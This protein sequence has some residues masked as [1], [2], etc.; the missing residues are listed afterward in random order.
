[1]RN[2]ATV[3]GALLLSSLLVVCAFGMTRTHD[4]A[5][6]PE[7]KVAPT[8]TPVNDPVPLFP[9]C[10]VLQI[11][12]G[13]SDNDGY[14]DAAEWA[15]ATV[16]DVSDTCGQSDGLPNELG[17]VYLYLMQ[18]DRCLYFGIDAVGDLYADYYDQ[19]GLYFDDND[20]GCWPPTGDE[21]E[22]NVWVVDDLTGLCYNIWRWWQDDG[23]AG[24]CNACL[25]YYG[26]YT[27]LGG[28][29]TLYDLCCCGLSTQSGHVQFEV[30]I[31]FG[32]AATET[33]MIQTYLNMGETVGLYMYYLDQYYYD[34]M[35]EMPCTGD[36]STFIWPCSWPSLIC[37]KQEFSFKMECFQYEVPIGGT[38]DLAKHF[39][40]NT[41][42]LMTIYDTIKAYRNDKLL[43]K[44]A[45]MWELPC[46]A[47]LD[48]C[49]A[50]GVPPKDQFICWD[51]T[52]VNQGVA[53][54][55]GME[56]PFE[57]AC[58]LHVMPGHKAEVTCP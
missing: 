13:T 34:F 10:G 12:S 20:D 4:N 11:G 24:N 19:A 5:L 27:N 47:D 39:H 15:G 37:V 56:Y 33:H 18:D 17:T 53:V 2:L 35:A 38:F 23:C 16:Y 28:F 54:A 50:L 52:I 7:G 31:Q 6:L 32:D 29:Y 55:G 8:R 49:F 30:G 25:D 41:C 48:V 3:A 14:I 36:G 46:E 26:N 42:E 9:D 51:V 21:T 22:G 44:F 45:F 58:D 40:N 1:M 57:G 43:K